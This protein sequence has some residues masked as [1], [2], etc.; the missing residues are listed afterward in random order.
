MAEMWTC[1]IRNDGASPVTIDDLGITIDATGQI[2][3]H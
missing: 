2:N 3:F 1:I